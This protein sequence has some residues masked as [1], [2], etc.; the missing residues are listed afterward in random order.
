[1]KSRKYNKSR[2]SLKR[3]S[4]KYNKSRK[5]LK[6]KSKKNKKSKK[7]NSKKGGNIEQNIELKN[8]IAQLKLK[9][10]DEQRNTMDQKKI[11][12]EIKKNVQHALNLE[13]DENTYNAIWVNFLK[14]NKEFKDVW[15]H[16]KN[17]SKLFINK[18][19]KKDKS[20]WF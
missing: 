10:E 12:E 13:E 4:R 2:K 5:S 6:R 3:K 15:N 8:Q 18:I 14:K 7:Y 11:I 16:Y 9:I 17:M 20:S 19:D 1:M